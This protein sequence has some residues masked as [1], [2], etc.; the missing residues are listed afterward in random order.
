MTNGIA[1]SRSGALLSTLALCVLLLLTACTVPTRQLLSDPDLLEK[2]E[3]HDGFGLIGGLGDE[4][5]RN[6][7]TPISQFMMAPGWFIS[8]IGL[9][10]VDTFDKDNVPS[11]I[12]CT[13]LWAPGLVL[14]GAG[15][16]EMWVADTVV[17]DI[18]TLLIGWPTED[19]ISI[20]KG[21]PYISLPAQHTPCACR[22]QPKRMCPHPEVEEAPQ[23]P[24][25]TMSQ[26][27]SAP[28]SAVES[29]SARPAIVPDPLTPTVGDY[30]TVDLGGGVELE[31]IWVP[32]GRFKMG[33][34]PIDASLLGPLQLDLD[35]LGDESPVH[36]VAVDGFWMAGTETT[37][38]QYEAVMG[39]NPS[40]HKGA[41]LPVD[42]V[43]WNDATEF[44]RKLSA[45]TGQTYSL[46]TE[47]QWEYACRAGSNG[48][49]CF[50]DDPDDLR[51]YAWCDSTLMV[52]AHPVATL[53][54]N[55][56]G[57][58]D[59][60]GNVWEWCQDWYDGRY[61]EKS[62][63]SNPKGPA[64]GEYRVKRGGGWSFLPRGTRSSYRGFKAPSFTEDCGGFRVCRIEDK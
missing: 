11:T 61:Y 18:P 31:V 12:A 28:Q 27:Q 49:W 40:A 58:Y 2:A 8:E 51:A 24:A 55:A 47:A 34:G 6:F 56:W 21:K 20:V 4:C 57:L 63:S 13:P 41:A 33:R 32:A 62:P 22:A 7:L 9:Y 44:C 36:S 54:P 42:S 29:P 45:L 38:A 59:M 1:V 50:G 30:R 17:H 43:S 15:L 39:H 23:P 16:T 10:G 37:Q 48:M 46:P 25:D 14:Y 19:F 5:P 26:S 53:K 3:R 35:G 64:S 52:G 60:H